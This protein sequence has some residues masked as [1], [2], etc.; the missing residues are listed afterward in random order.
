MRKRKILR[1]NLA[2]YEGKLVT[3]KRVTRKRVA[4]P[5]YGEVIREAEGYL[6]LTT[7]FK[8]QGVCHYDNFP[9][10]VTH[11]PTRWS[12]REGFALRRV[13][14]K[15]FQRPEMLNSLLDRRLRYEDN[16]GKRISYMLACSLP[17]SGW[18]WTW[19]LYGRLP[20]AA[21][22]TLIESRSDKGGIAISNKLFR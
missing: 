22:A 6:D 19:E 4:T 12:S 13:K 3:R 21:K 2:R 9:K 17:Q 20:G 10:R 7:W 8:A 11:G 18:R 15:G 14:F 1:A 16:T 5:E